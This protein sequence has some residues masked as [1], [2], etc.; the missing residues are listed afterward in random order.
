MIKRLL[1]LFVL[2]SPSTI[3]ANEASSDRFV[4]AERAQNL[5]NLIKSEVNDS[6]RKVYVVKVTDNEEESNAWSLGTHI[7][8][9]K[10][11]M[12]ILDD[13]T[14]LAVIAHEMAHREKW[15]QFSR[16]G[17]Y[18]GG[19]VVAFFDSLFVE[20]PETLK[21]RFYG[22]HQDYH[23]RQEM[24]ADCL[25]YNWLSEL[26]SKGFEADPLDLNVARNQ[27]SGVDFDK[28]SQEYFGD[29]PEFIRHQAVRRGYGLKC[30]L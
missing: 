10:K 13:R 12:R 30:P 24:Q 22:F 29:N 5:V 9:T 21:E 25:A 27:M 14:L 7:L 23:T 15:H 8:I 18:V 28:A 6:F 3:F 17:M 20:R 4:Q 11:A 1:L 2:L 16:M 19:S 26:K